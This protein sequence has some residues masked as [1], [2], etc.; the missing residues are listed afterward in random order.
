MPCQRE[1]CQSSGEA[2]E[3]IKL[4]LDHRVAVSQQGNNENGPLLIVCAG[5]AEEI[6]RMDPPANLSANGNQQQPV[7]PLVDLL[8]P[9]LQ[10]ATTCDNTVTTKNAISNSVCTTR[11]VVII[12]YSLSF[13]ELPFN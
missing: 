5:C 6:K 8:L 3:S 4:C 11:I 2:A 7:E 13:A 12:R 1:E 10:V 9:M